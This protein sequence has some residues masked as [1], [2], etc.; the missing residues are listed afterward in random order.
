MASKSQE[1]QISRWSNE[2]WFEGL[3]PEGKFL[4]E[5]IVK[6]HFYFS[7]QDKKY[8]NIVRTFKIL[9]LL[10]AM[11]STI[12]LGLKTIICVDWQIVIGLVLSAF[13]T[14]VTAL[15]SYFNFEE[16][17]MRN[18]SIHI[19]LN[20][21]RDDFIFEAQSCSVDDEALQCYRKK[22][23]DIQKNNIKYWEKAIKNI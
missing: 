23:D 5:L 16:Y 8:R 12:V 6:Y 2:D 9:I 15:S 7:Q 14:F 10:F 13:I 20:I 1:K 18:I 19:W 21:I 17:W 3:K 11:A 22:L 4:F